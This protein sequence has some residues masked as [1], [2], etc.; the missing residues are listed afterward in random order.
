MSVEIMDSAMKKDFLERMKARFNN[1]IKCANSRLYGMALEC[2]D[3]PSR[4]RNVETQRALS[5]IPVQVVLSDEQPVDTCYLTK[6]DFSKWDNNLNDHFQDRYQI[7][8]MRRFI[9]RARESIELDEND[10]YSL[11]SSRLGD[12]RESPVPT[13]TIY[14]RNHSY[15]KKWMANQE[16][17]DLKSC[18]EAEI[19]MTYAHEYCHHVHHCAFKLMGKKY[20]INGS[21]E[22]RVVAESLADYY[23]IWFLGERIGVGDPL[24]A[25]WKV[26]DE[27]IRLWE[28]YFGSPWPYAYALLIERSRQKTIRWREVFN[29]SISSWHEAYLT[30]MD[31]TNIQPFEKM[32]IDDS[33]DASASRNSKRSKVSS[34]IVL[35]EFGFE[36]TKPT[37][38]TSSKIPKDAFVFVYSIPGQ[39]IHRTKDVSD[40][41]QTGQYEFHTPFLLF[42]LY[43]PEDPVSCELLKDHGTDLC[44]RSSANVTILTFLKKEVT[45]LWD[46]VIHDGRT[47]SSAKLTKTR[48]HDTLQTFENTFDASKPFLILVKKQ[49]GEEESAVISLEGMDSLQQ[50][51]VL[52]DVLHE[53]DAHP[54]VDVDSL[55]HQFNGNMPA[56]FT[57]KNGWEESKRKLACHDFFQKAKNRMPGRL[58]TIKFLADGLHCDEDVVRF[59]RDNAAFTR[60]E[61]LKLGI[62]FYLSIDEL[63]AFLRLNGLCDLNEEEERAIKRALSNPDPRRY[64]GK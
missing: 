23:A 39:E 32:E 42:Y 49:N 58:R 11:T 27:R 47:K 54:D 19:C 17:P 14:Y 13:I 38:P 35:A 20:A 48:I 36:K 15:F 24:S 41:L 5:R 46:N 26:T 51:H 1:C 37:F 33:I 31:G 30:L 8:E 4:K 9:S 60:G 18:F 12:Y 43:D 56:L 53:M 2:F 61:C 16:D 25:Y 50:F 34:D 63:N 44:N 45:N 64:L 57:K 7:E 22:R 29:Q 59:K 6:E 40:F 28:K 62:R 10:R 55:S 52:E 3:L 21:W